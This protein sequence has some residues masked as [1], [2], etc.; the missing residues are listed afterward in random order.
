MANGEGV[1]FSVP[2]QKSFFSPKNL[3]AVL[4]IRR[5]L[6][7]ERFDAVILNTALAAFLIRIAMVGMRRRPKVLNISHGYLFHYP[8]QGK[9]DRLMRICEK[10][11]ARY[12][13]E[14]AVMNGEDLRICKDHRLCR[15]AVHFM[16]GMG[17][18]ISVASACADPALRR[19][20]ATEG[21]YLLTFVGELSTRKNQ[22]FLILT[23]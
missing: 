18:T 6:K 17:Y 20:F 19:Q 15:G 7:R 21:D 22:L 8:L 5:I 14:I 1:D 16:R 23:L 12:T 10:L 3:G 13:D 11:T 2:F 4:Q 9:K